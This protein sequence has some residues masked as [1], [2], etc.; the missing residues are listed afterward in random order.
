MTSISLARPMNQELQSEPTDERL[1]QR[2]SEETYTEPISRV[3]PRIMATV[4]ATWGLCFFII[5]GL[6]DAHDL[7]GLAM[8]S[9]VGG[10]A[11]GIL[12]GGWFGFYVKRFHRSLLRRPDKYFNTPPALA[13]ETLVLEILGNQRRG[14][15]FVG[16][17]AVLTET[18]FWFV[19][20]KCN[21]KA[22]LDPVRIPLSEIIDVDIVERS[23][24]ERW[25]TGD[26]ADLFPG[27]VR[28]GTKDAVYEF[29]AG[30]REMVARLIAELQPRLP[31][32]NEVEKALEWGLE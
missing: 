6:V 2:F 16:G 10:G 19:P 23:V 14:D 32:A 15:A 8:A 17:K 27:R 13:E 12:W 11:F 25:F 21:G 29:S 3:T 22:Y 9:A 26:R 31:G 4:G 28:I 5:I 18:A 30:T 1:P 7:G 20:H 24:V